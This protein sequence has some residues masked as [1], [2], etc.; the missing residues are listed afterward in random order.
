MTNSSAND[1]AYQATAYALLA[2]KGTRDESAQNVQTYLE[3]LIGEFGVVDPA[4]NLETYEV[5]GEILRAL[6]YGDL[7]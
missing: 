5:D 1:N 3:S 4:T 7:K 2:F 6:S